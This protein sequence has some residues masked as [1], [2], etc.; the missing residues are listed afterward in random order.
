MVD[1]VLPPDQPA[2]FLNLTAGPPPFSAM[3]STLA[4]SRA[5]RV[6]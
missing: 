5:A 3:N 6:L 4:S 1:A 2:P